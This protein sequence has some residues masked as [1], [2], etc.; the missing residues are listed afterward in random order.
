MKTIITLLTFL[1]GMSLGSSIYA[2]SLTIS[3]VDQTNQDEYVAADPNLVTVPV[4]IPVISTDE[5]EIDFNFFS[6]DEDGC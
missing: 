6:D 3:A 4:T 5:T 2:E 1:I